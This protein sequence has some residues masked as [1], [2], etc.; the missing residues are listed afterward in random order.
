MFEA[1]FNLDWLY[2]WFLAELADTLDVPKRLISIKDFELPLPEWLP[3]YALYRVLVILSWWILI[4]L[5]L[6]SCKFL[7]NFFL[8]ISSL[9]HFKTSK[10]DYLLCSLLN[11]AWLSVTICRWSFN[12]FSKFKDYFFYSAKKLTCWL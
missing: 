7:S 5:L 6:N 8:S 11:I 1:F 2:W 4:S 10:F 12:L 3:F 9:C